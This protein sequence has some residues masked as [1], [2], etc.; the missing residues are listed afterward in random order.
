MSEERFVAPAVLGLTRT[1]RAFVEALVNADER[2][3]GKD[4]MLDALYGG[5]EKAEPEPK[6]IDVFAC[7]VRSKLMKFGLRDCI[8]TV[9]GRGYVCRGEG[10]TM[11]L[12]AALPTERERA[13]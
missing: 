1:E 11:L 3:L 8:E 5:R 10:R 9:W 6:I 4:A 13:A 2:V 12:A 7:K